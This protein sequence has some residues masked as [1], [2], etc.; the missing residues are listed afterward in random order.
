MTVSLLIVGA[1]VRAAAGSA[2]RAGFGP[3]GVD[4]FSDEDLRAMARSRRVEPGSYPGGLV[5]LAE[6]E[7]AGPWMYTGAL[8]N[9][10]ELID[11]ISAGRPLWGNDGATTRTVR[12]PMAM[13][14]VL[15][16]RGLPALE[17]L[18]DPAGLPEDGSWLIKPLRSAGGMGIRPWLG[19]GSEA[20]GGLPSY[21]QR[22]KRGPSG[23]AVFLADGRSGV[24]VGVTRQWIG[25]GAGPFGYLGSVGPVGIPGEMREQLERTGRVLSR[26]FGLRGLFGIDFVSEGGVAWPTEVNPRYSAS[27]EV[28][29]WATGRTLLREHAAVF[30]GAIDR[31][32]SCR[33]EIPSRRVG[34]LI[35]FA[36]RDGSIPENVRW[37]LDD[38]A[39]GRFPRLADLPAPG[40]RFRAGQPVLTLLERGRSA[41]ECR[42]RLF[43]RLLGWRRRLDRWARGLP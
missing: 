3:V 32:S 9:H 24:L 35:V 7:P 25:G 21:Y 27:V 13:A 36:R 26:A 6:A 4:L 29:E 37:R 15:R 10:P 38:L 14:E 12:D 23:S 19:I 18:L 39:A 22:R 11:R 31:H 40:S 20:G 41:G 2:L 17:V 16:S 30:D 8:E 43:R 42:R 28:L 1:S 5:R 33:V 34:K